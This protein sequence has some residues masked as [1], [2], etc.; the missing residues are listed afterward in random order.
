ME[1]E[2]GFIENHMTRS[3]DMMT[4]KIKTLIATMISRVSK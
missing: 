4:L 3:D 2:L 1:W